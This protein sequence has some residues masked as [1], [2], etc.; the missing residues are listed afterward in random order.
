MLKQHM[1]EMYLKCMRHG[2]NMCFNMIGSDLGKDEEHRKDA[3]ALKN[4]VQ[5]LSLLLW[6]SSDC[7]SLNYHTCL[8]T[9]VN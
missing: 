9:Y 2:P 8:H 3:E 4:S 5:R 1:F 7:T 6:S